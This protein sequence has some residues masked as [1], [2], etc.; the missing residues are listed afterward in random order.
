MS[1]IKNVTF[2]GGSGLLGTFVLD[3]LLSSIRFN[4]QVL[5]RAGSSSTY[6]AG[7]KVVET[8]FTDFESL[9]VAFE[10]QDAVV[11]VV[12]EAGLLGQKIMVDAAIAAGVKRFLP[13]NFGSNMSNP[14]SRML[15]VFAPK[16]VVE[17]YLVEK[18]KTTE[19]TYT[20]VYTG[21]FTDF[22]IQKN[23][24]VDF[25]K[26][27]PTL[28]DGGDY[29]FSSTSMSTIGDA[30]VGV[31]SHPT[32]TRNRPV[33]VSE[34]IL[35]QNQLLAV[36]RKIAPSKPWNPVNASLDAM[37]E[38]SKELFAK[39][40]HDLRTALPMLLKSILDPEFGTEFTEN[41]NELLGIKTATEEYVVE[42]L[43]SLLN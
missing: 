20:F 27:Q 29:R 39:G 10:G 38:S 19:L 28:F 15:P 3:K 22:A 42:L 23:I 9:K 37:L 7:A 35:S 41:D 31:L 12:G 26:Y 33:Y 40:Q 21:V 18:S 13:S 34:I 11:S 24:I 30:V 1:A 6:A 36:A 4:V 14:N 17:D 43:T 32:E 5:K 25:S 16:V 8:D 2:V